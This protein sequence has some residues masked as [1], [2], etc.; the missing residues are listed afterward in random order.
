MQEYGCVSCH[1]I[2]GVPGGTGRVGPPLVAMADRAYVAGVLPNT[3]ESLIRWI[4]YPTEVNP[5]TAMPEMGVT[6]Q[7]AR[8]IAAYLHGLYAQP[9]AVRMLR[10]FVERAIGRQVPAEPFP[11]PAER[12][13]AR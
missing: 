7:D 8:D 10:G 2:P 11:A 4:R 12:E 1:T 13:E 3:P 6:E 5:R 9:R